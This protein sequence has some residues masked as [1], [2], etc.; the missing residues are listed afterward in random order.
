MYETIKLLFDI[1]LFRKGPADIPYSR[2]LQKI[3]LLTYASVRFLMLNFDM[4][5]R[6]VLLHIGVEITFIWSFSW[7][8]LYCIGRLPR[9]C[10]VTSTFYGTFAVIGFFTLPAFASIAIGHG[11]WLVFIVML[12]ITSWF[13]AV[14]AHI[15]YHTLD[16]R[17]SLSIGV[18]FLFLMGSYLLLDFLFPDRFGII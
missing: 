17:L 4:D 7:I 8:M 14:T 1:C 6:N 5:W 10:Q 11:G 13:C 3:L 15:I 18:A 9:L 2:W 16:Q 12:A